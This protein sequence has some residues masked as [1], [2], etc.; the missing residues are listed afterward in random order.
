MRGIIIVIALLSMHPAGVATQA[1]D[2]AAAALIKRAAALTG[3]SN[4]VY[5][6]I[7][8]RGN[9]GKNVG[10][11][12]NTISYAAKDNKPLIIYSADAQLATRAITMAFSMIRPNALKG[13]AIICAV[14]KKNDG[15]IRPVI[16]ATGARLYVE[17]LP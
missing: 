6:Y 16:E 14:G 3:N 10:K 11:L 9:F 12:A 4:G 8:P 1:V 2:P 13:C 7:P 5:F 17:P 15:Y